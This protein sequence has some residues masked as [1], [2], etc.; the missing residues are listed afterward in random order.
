VKPQ[1]L[2]MVTRVDRGNRRS[3]GSVARVFSSSG[4]LPKSEMAARLLALRVKKTRRLTIRETMYLVLSEPS[5]GVAARLVSFAVRFV[6]LTVTIASTLETCRD[7]SL[8]GGLLVRWGD[9]PYRYVRYAGNGFFIAE[10]ALRVLFYMPCRGVLLDPF[11]WLDLLTPMPFVINTLLI[12]MRVGSPRA[13]LILEAWGSIR[14]LKLCRYYEGAGLLAKAVRRSVDQLVVPLFMLGVLVL[15]CGSVLYNIELDHNID[16]CRNL[17][18]DEGVDTAFLYGSPGGVLWGC[19]ACTAPPDPANLSATRCATCRGYPEGHPQCLGVPFVQPYQTIPHAMW[20]L[21]V[22]VT[23]VGYGDVS[24]STILGQAFISLVALLGIIFLAMP[25]SVVGNNFQHVWDDK[26]YFKLQ[27]L[28]RQMLAENDMSPA[29]CMTAFKQFDRDGDG[30]IDRNEFDFFVVQVLGLKLHRQELSK[31][32]SMLDSNLSGSVNYAEFGAMLFPDHDFSGEADGEGA[33]E[34]GAGAVL[35]ACKADAPREVSLARAAGLAKADAE[36]RGTPDE[37]SVL[38]RGL[39]G[40]GLV[41]KSVTMAASPRESA[42][43]KSEDATD[44]AAPAPATAAAT[45]FCNNTNPSV[46]YGRMGRVW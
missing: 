16:D 10:A 1:M 38:G 9:A 18:E 4:V 3:S 6:T 43:A 24:P 46:A 35:S 19:E 13:L 37:R 30:L 23:T 15:V 12:H 42:G 45:A 7:P 25:L 44:A 41:A 17:W 5:S 34:P 31:L 29:D 22:T 39:L 28:T 11:I 40:P 32:W 8:F 27:S 33:R 14:L 20:F 36:T 21:V 26:A 2:R